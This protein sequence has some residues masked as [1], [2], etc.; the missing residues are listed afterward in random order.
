MRTEVLKT[1]VQEVD[2]VNT[3]IQ[4]LFEHFPNS[5]INFYLEDFDKILRVEAPVLIMNW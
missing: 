2:D 1:N 4:K 3:L 5:K